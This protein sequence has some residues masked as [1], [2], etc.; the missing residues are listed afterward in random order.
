MRLRFLFADELQ[1]LIPCLVALQEDSGEGR[2]GGNGI[3]LLYSAHGHAGVH[4]LD[5]HSHAQR[6]QGFLQ[7]VT[8]LL[9][10]ALLHLQAAGI[11]LNHTGHLAQAGNLTLGDI[12]DMSFAD[13]GQHVMLAKGEKFNVL[14]DDHVVV[15]LLEQGALHDGLPILEITLCKELHGLGYA[16]GRLLQPFP[17]SIF[18]KQPKNG[19]DVPRN[20]LRG[21]F[22]V[23][24][25]LPVC[26]GLFFVAKLVRKKRIAKIHKKIHYIIFLP[27]FA[28]PFG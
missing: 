25:N 13:K 14:H 5:D 27:I 19:L 26:H 2:C 6:I 10:E 21:L 18:T 8:N 15:G 23:F 9:R 12:S 3:G 1:E 24:F 22:I 4:S 17:G 28:A 7:A 20:L 16:F 11:G